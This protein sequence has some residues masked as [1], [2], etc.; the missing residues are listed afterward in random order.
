LYCGTRA[1][2]NHPRFAAYRQRQLDKGLS[3]IAAR[4]ALARKLARIAFTL[5][6][7]Q[8]TFTAEEKTYCMAP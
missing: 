5:M 8:Q 2:C 7:Q 6:N 1:A 3:K 4:V